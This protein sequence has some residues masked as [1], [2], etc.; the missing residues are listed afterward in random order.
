MHIHGMTIKQVF[1]LGLYYGIGY[2]LPRK[3]SK[4]GG[5]FLVSSDI[6]AASIFLNR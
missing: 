1:F 5:Y 6:C 4:W 3:T 2:H